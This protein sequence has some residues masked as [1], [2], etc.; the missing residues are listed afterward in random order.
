MRRLLAALLA[1][2]AWSAAIVGGEDES[3]FAAALERGT[4]ELEQG[5]LDAARVEIER[6]LERDPKSPAAWALRAKLAAAAKDVDEQLWA[7][8]RHYGLRVAQKAKPA[9]LAPLRAEIEALDPIAP[10]LLDLKAAFVE[11]L[12]PLADS[13]EKERRP[14]SAIR[15]HQQL[16]ALDPERVASLDAI[17]RISATPDPSL[18]ETAQARDLFEGIS[19]EWIRK[20]DAD[21][22]TWEKCG[23]LERPNYVTK[24]DAGYEVM[25][26]AAEAMEQMNSFYREFFRYGTDEDGKSVP[27]IALHIFK[28]RDEY[29]K[30]GIGPPVEWSGGHFTG[31]AVETYVGP[32][33]FEEVTTTLFHEAAHQ[34]VGL[35]TTAVGWL[36][37]GLASFFEG[38][39]I[40]ANGTVL[41][42]MPANHRLFPLAEKMEQ[43]WMSGP[44]DGI[45]A[46]D[47]NAEPRTAP[48]FRIVL[49][50][51]YQ[52]GPPWYAP[53]WGVVY[54]LWNYQ[55]PLDGRFVYRAA[56]RDF[57][58]SSGGRSGEGAVE[59]FEKVVLAKPAAPTKGVDFGQRDDEFGLPKTVAELDEV[60]K[61]WILALRDEQTGKLEPERPWLAWAKHALTR[62]DH[63][64]AKE[65]FEK[66]IVD[67]PDDVELHLEFARW[68][69]SREKGGKGPRA[70][71]R[72][73]KLALRALQLIE[74]QEKVDEKKLKEADALLAALDPKRRILDRVLDQLEA[75]ASGIAERYLAAGRPRMAMEV[76]YRLGTELNFPKLFDLFER[77]ATASGKSLALWQLAYDEKGFDG[78][79][80]AGNDA[81]HPAGAEITSQFGD[82]ESG[83]FDYQ[84]LIRDTVTSGDF[85]FE[86]ELLA[87]NNVLS[88]AGLVFGKK[89]GSTFHTLVYYP[90]R[91]ADARYNVEGRQAAVDLTSFYGAGDF[92]VWRHN[93]LFGTVS[94]WHRLRVDVTG[95]MVD[96]WCDGELVVSQEFPSLDVLRG[97]FGLITG[98]GQARWR[99]LRYLARHP[100]DPGAL[101]EREITMQRLKEAA[102]KSG[103]PIGSSYVGAVPPFPTAVKWVRAPRASFEEAGP[104]PQL[105]VFFSIA[106]NDRLRIDGW[107]KEFAD[108]WRDVGL[109]VICI[110]APDDVALEAYLASHS[111]V[112]AAGHDTRP[113]G[114]QSYGTT[115]EQYFIQRFN[116]PRVL[117]L[118]V[119]Q[120]VA[121]EGDP[122]FNFNEPWTPGA[123]SVLDAPMDELV[124]RRAIRQL[125]AWRNAWK[126]GGAAAWQAGDLAT[127]LPLLKQ[128]DAMPN[129]LD[130]QVVAVRGQLKIVRSAIASIDLT[131]A[132]LE[133]LG[134]AEA[135]ATLPTLY[136]WGELLGVPLAEEDKKALAP[137][138][139]M[140]AAK[141]FTQLVAHGKALKKAIEGK[142]GVEA[143]RPLLNEASAG[144][145][146]LF[147]RYRAR[148]E[149]RIAAGDPAALAGW[150]EAAE[151]RV[152]GEWLVQ[153]LF[154]W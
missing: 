32:G 147:S 122:G 23:V 81:F 91:A 83:K 130:L 137:K 2:A 114:R 105:L 142:A 136:A 10:D 39:R 15:V 89:S 113:R 107:L 63:L 38:C 44:D 84:F 4:R 135:L 3:P 80:D 20:F 59:N 56:F 75:A 116:L 5:Q 28:T 103:T 41:M 8:H 52:W 65:H 133:R 79:I 92:R 25:V 61:R 50:N 150:L 78:W 82:L 73:A 87:E 144:S 11:R 134:G 117:L 127:A 55:D 19:E 6:A 148:L 129:A 98:P 102:A 128:V 13:Y 132:K 139:A 9:E 100:R 111:F 46:G 35:A 119:D 21:H 97:N 34:F 7:L 85:S 66:G 12:A 149:E 112:G 71:D 14:H 118:D 16:L 126:D 121:W 1:S 106:Q 47:P 131:A 64:A 43:G 22:G 24:T 123:P 29:L 68:L 53:T 153:E 140:P 57:I 36:N 69:Q 154:R 72:A 67:Q 90:G 94:G 120:R 151:L 31:N 95:R 88:F 40:L 74:G 110:G 17:E 96:V 109:Q 125:P 30:L 86:A 145:G 138:L 54:F 115:F 51:K 49:E 104:V 58:D 48:T 124:T 33:G 93:V 62:K 76:S 146:P 152:G 18:A 141:A 27:R 60:W 101:I 26:R 77:A 108:K 45:S 99:N 42:N 37:E 70:S 143:A